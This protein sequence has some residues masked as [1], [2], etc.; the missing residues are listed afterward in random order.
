M[1]SSQKVSKCRDGCELGDLLTGGKT[2]I[3]TDIGSGRHWKRRTVEMFRSEEKVW[4]SRNTRK[5]S[6][7]VEI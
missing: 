3:S 5:K 1:V 4:S 6:G 2:R 7:R